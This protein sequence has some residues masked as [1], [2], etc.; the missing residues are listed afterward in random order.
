MPALLRAYEDLRHARTAEVQASSRLNQHIFHLPDGAAQAERDAQMRETL[1]GK[2]YGTGL[3]PPRTSP[4]AKGAQHEG[5]PN[6]WADVRKSDALF[7]YDAEAAA[8][9]WLVEHGL[10]TPGDDRVAPE[11][12]DDEDEDELDVARDDVVRDVATL[13]APQ[14]VP[15]SVVALQSS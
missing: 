15:I 3:P 14:E 5:N 4:R 1:N 12:E 7:G 10:E 6:Q 2:S 8:R 9:S 11:P 13:V